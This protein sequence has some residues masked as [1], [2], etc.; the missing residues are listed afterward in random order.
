[1]QIITFIL[2]ALV[3]LSIV[4]RNV[5]PMVMLLLMPGVGA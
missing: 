1:M 4:C 3:K 2:D 5:T